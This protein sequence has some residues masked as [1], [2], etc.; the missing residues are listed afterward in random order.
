MPGAPKAPLLPQAAGIN[1]G[2]SAERVS[3]TLDDGVE[4]NREHPH[5]YEIPPAEERNNLVP[6]QLVKLVFRI[7]HGDEVD[8]ERMWVEV[9]GTRPGGY[10]GVLDNDPYY[11]DG[12]R[13]GLE[14]EFEPRHVIQIYSAA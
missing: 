5:T 9:T 7:A 13:H 1:G 4:I 3:Y 14:I 11:T 10:V 6:G 12:I 8:V 2:M